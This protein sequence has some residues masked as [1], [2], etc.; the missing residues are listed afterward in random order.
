[1]TDV[2]YERKTMPESISAKIGAARSGWC[3]NYG[4]IYVCILRVRAGNFEW[5]LNL[6]SQAAPRG[7]PFREK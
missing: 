2:M 7:V 3:S 6:D 1:M 4:I 5:T